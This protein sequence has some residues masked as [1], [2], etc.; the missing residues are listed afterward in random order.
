MWKEK[1]EEVINKIRF[2]LNRIL[3]IIGIHSYK[4]LKGRHRLDLCL[5]FFECR[6]CKKIIERNW[7]IRRKEIRG[8]VKKPKSDGIYLP[9]EMRK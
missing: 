5:A 7:N 1:K 3:C 6:Y 9:K 4:E 2:I 8:V